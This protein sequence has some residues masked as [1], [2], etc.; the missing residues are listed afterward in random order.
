MDTL[1]GQ[2][3]IATGFDNPFPGLRP[4]DPK[5]AHLFFGREGQSEEILE[6]LAANK[7]AAILGASGSGKSSLIYCGLL[8]ILYGGFLHNGRS[9]WRVVISRP[10]TG[11]IENLAQSMASAFSK[12]ESDPEI[13][14]DVL[15]NQAVLRRSADGISNVI[16]QSRISNDENVLILVDQFEE[17]FRYQYS[18]KDVD[19]SDRVEHFVNLLVSIVQQQELPVYVVITMRSDFIGDCSPFQKLTRLINDSHYLIPRMTR[20]DFRMAITGPIAVGGGKISDQLVQL[21]LNEMGNNPD[22]LPILQ[23]SLMRTWEFWVKH[24]DTNNPIG[25]IEY[26]AI[27][28]LERA[29]SNH[30]NEA[31]DELSVD[32]KRI[33]EVI[34]KSLTE[35]GAD[36]RGI[37][38]PTSVI[39]LA[40]IAETTPDE[41]IRVVEVFRMIGRTFLT[42][43]PHIELTPDSIVDISHESLMRVWD[44]LK[45]WVED[46]SSAVKMYLRLAESAEMYSEGKTSLWGPPDL[47]LGINWREKQNPNLAWAVRYHPA[48]ERTIVYLRTSEEEYIA[49]E[50]NKIRLQK[51]AL[52]R[53]R[54]FALILGTAGMISIGLGILALI[55]RQDALKAQSEA[56]EQKDFAEEQRIEAEAQK[57]LAD[58]NAELARQRQEEAEKSQKE[59]ETQRQLAFEN[60]NEADRQRLLATQKEKEATDNL[61]LAEENAQRAQEQQQLAEQASL[62]AE[63]RRMVSIAQSMAVKSQQLR[64]DTTLKGLLA[65]QAFA[66]NTD[67]EGVDYNPDIYKSL[68]LSSKFFKGDNYNILDGHSSLVRTLHHQ[69][70]KLYSSGSDGQLFSWDIESK[71]NKLVRGNL[72]IVKKI[73]VNGNEV[74]GINNNGIFSLNMASDEFNEKVFFPQDIKDFF[75]TKDKKIILVFNQT[76]SIAENYLSTPVEIYKTQSR[77]NASKYD[78]TTNTIF[79]ALAD[80]K[81][82]TLK[83]TSDMQS[84]IQIAD[85]PESNWGEIGYSAERKILAAGFGNNQGA[86][87]LWD[88]E[89]RQQLN[90]LRGHN[91]KITG[92][93]FSSDGK[94]MAS[95]SYD[96]SVRL[97]HMD[98]LN[99]LPIVFDD[100]ETWVTSVTFTPDGKYVISGDKNG[101]IRRLPV[102]VNTLIT[103]FCQFLTRKLT[104]EEWNNYVGEDV[105]YSPKDC[106]AN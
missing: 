92:V 41:V 3:K 104:V 65:Y 63:R 80:G 73:I 51:R 95:A 99:T 56:V 57:L 91:A 45:I 20:D 53:T 90:V 39:E 78:P 37:R 34:F 72:S 105:E 84:P 102:D 29:L 19:A 8:P 31:Y 93:A 52:R 49:E 70:G 5:E 83:N 13:E 18:G 103:D 50:E 106:V 22:H 27:G 2:N 33:C 54:I 30:A 76:I 23:H 44:K 38:R 96:G 7:F 14:S 15:I 88:M 62:D 43:P 16:K 81:I 89:K 74:L 82:I 46:E 75:V 9:K 6:N 55:Q 79:L 69:S 66:F 59:A 97:W 100:H 58:Q 42:P 77:I 21:L 71:E 4:F 25:I 101:R 85:L 10:G 40:Q 64:V 35:K 48:F 60:L 67:Y 32:Q 1:S 68:Y 17:I 12:G 86:I 87:Y 26:E 94:Y 47:Q 36:N 98:D 28:R 11:P 61:I 24:S